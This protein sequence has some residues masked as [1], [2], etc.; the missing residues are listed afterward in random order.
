MARPVD[1]QEW[2][3]EAAMCM[4]RTGQS[5]GQ[6]A[7]ELGQKLTVDEAAALLRKVSFQRLLFEERN[8]YFALLGAD[9]N[10]K[11][12]TAVGK[13]LDLA[14]KLEEV[15]EFDRAADTIFKVS[16]MQGWVGPES[17]VNVFGE[18]SQKDL[19]DI[20]EKIAKQK[21]M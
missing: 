19:D 9:P 2:H 1:L 21:V 13:M 14:K 18:L 10:F 7:T 15:G 12:E 16:K 20:K 8:R 11:K 3:L 5:L 17:T 4:A 6:V